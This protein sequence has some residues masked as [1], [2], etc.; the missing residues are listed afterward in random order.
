MTE[1]RASMRHLLHRLQPMTERDHEEPNRVATTLELLY[2]LTLVVAF[3]VAGVQL[4]HA[5]AVGQVLPG[6]VSFGIVQFATVWAWMN[7]SW[8]A[9]AFDTDDWG[10]RLCVGFQMVGILILATD[11]PALFR[12]MA[13]GWRFDPI[14]M[15]V[16]YVVMRVAMVV[17]WL[18]AA[19]ANPER[20]RV[21]RANAAWTGVVQVLWVVSCFVDLGFASRLWVAVLLIVVEV[22]APVLL[23]WRRY[24]GTS[25]HPHHIAERHGL[26][27][28]ISLG[29]IVVGTAGSVST[30]HELHGW[31]PSAA[32]VL[33]CGIS[34]AVS[35]WWIYFCLPFGQALH[36]RRDL[37][38]HFGYL[39]FFI[40]ASIAAVG[41][42]L[43]V[44]ALREQGEADLS[45]LSSLLFLVVPLALFII[46]VGMLVGLTRVKPRTRR[47]SLVL[48]G[49][50]LGLLGLSVLLAL[51]GAPYVVCMVVAMLAPWLDVIAIETTGHR[52]LID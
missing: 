21:F 2:D 41:A 9:S 49:L 43:H 29:E 51:L 45:T 47:A 20:A 6:L 44:M 25:F 19:R 28:I 26:L 4:A 5:I 50:T 10:V 16:G 14:V 48:L 24:G 52:F 46:T 22:A 39:H 8:F 32:G 38:F 13:D 37:A 12:N 31:W 7:Y 3:G 42:G 33:V 17:M 34:I 30:L 40:Y 1:P 23:L 36:R 35:M 27:V 18:R 15:V 11:I